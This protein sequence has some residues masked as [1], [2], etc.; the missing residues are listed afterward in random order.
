[1]HNDYKEM[2]TDYQEMQQDY[3]EKWLQNTCIVFSLCVLL[4]CRRGVGVLPGRQLSHNLSM[5]VAFTVNSPENVHHNKEEPYCFCHAL[6]R[7]N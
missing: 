5:A 3:K 1:M 6:I 2:Q 4:L 7:T